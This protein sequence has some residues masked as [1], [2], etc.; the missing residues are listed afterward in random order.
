MCVSPARRDRLRLLW[1]TTALP[2]HAGTALKLASAL[3]GATRVVDEQGFRSYDGKK[4][5][6]VEIDKLAYF[7]AS[8]FWR[9]AVRSWTV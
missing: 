2:G 8:I 9:A 6:G 1:A 3:M 7:G 5:P 4:I